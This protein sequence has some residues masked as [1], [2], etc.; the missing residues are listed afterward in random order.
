MGLTQGS[1]AAVSLPQAFIQGLGTA[2]LTGLFALMLL[3]VA[4]VI[5]D[6]TELRNA[7]L[8]DLP[9]M[10]AVLFI[11]ALWAVPIATLVAW[12]PI[13]V[14]GWTLHR[15]ARRWAVLASGW[16]HAA[17]GALCGAVIHAVLD[18]DREATDPA[19]LAYF[20]TTGIFAALMFR[21]LTRG[22]PAATFGQD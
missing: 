14:V 21:R 8:D 7:S 17:V 3:P 18:L 22:A 12:L 1:P 20:A 9:E 19:M 16:V 2:A 13:T 6:P 15:A 5:S 10:I 4:M 11:G